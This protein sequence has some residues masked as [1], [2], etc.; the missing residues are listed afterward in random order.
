MTSSTTHEEDD[1]LFISLNLEN[2]RHGGAK[3]IHPMLETL[4][5]VKATLRK[6]FEIVDW[7]GIEI[8]LAVTVAFYTL[9]E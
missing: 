9:G 6:H 8:I 4:E 2:F 7:Q 5:G 3:P 1:P